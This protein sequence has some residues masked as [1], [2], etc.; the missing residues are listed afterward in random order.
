M[1]IYEFLKPI[2]DM[3][4]WNLVWLI[5]LFFICYGIG[6]GIASVI[7]KKEEKEEKTE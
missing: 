6:R 1:N 4:A 5:P 2:L 3:N 7:F